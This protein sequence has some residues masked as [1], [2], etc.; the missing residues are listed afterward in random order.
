VKSKEGCSEFEFKVNQDHLP[1]IHNNYMM[2]NYWLHSSG[3]GDT[4]GAIMDEAMTQA[5]RSKR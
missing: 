1:L 2:V 3:Y 4:R 5:E